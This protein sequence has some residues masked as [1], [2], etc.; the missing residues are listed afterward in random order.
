MPLVFNTLE[1]QVTLSLAGMFNSQ[2][3][4]YRKSC[5]CMRSC[6]VL[7]FDYEDFQGLAICSSSLD[8]FDS[9]LKINR[10]Q[11]WHIVVIFLKTHLSP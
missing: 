10:E 2:V 1:M 8:K 11:Q 4:C 6:R 7:H 3:P 5:C 9:E